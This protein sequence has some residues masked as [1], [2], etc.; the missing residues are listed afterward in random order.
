MISRWAINGQ[1]YAVQAKASELSQGKKGFAYYMDMGLGKTAVALN[2][3]VESIQRD[4][5][6]GAIV[7]CINSLKSN[8]RA[9]VVSWGV[10]VPVTLWPD[11][12]KTVPF[13]WVINFD[14]F[15]YAG[16]DEVFAACRKHR[17][18]CFIDESQKIK[19]PNG[20]VSKSILSLR[21]EFVFKRLLSGSPMTNTVM[22]LWPQFNF[23]GATNMNPYAFRNRF[24]IT[25]GYMGK[26]V[27]G[28][29]NEDLLNELKAGFVFRA[30]KDEW[31]DLPEKV[32][33]PP[34]EIKMS[35]AQLKSY[36]GMHEDL[37]VLISEL[38]LTGDETDEVSVNLVVT[39]LI[40]LQQ[41]AAG[42]IITEEGHV[43]ELVPANK[44][45]RVL[46]TV[47]VG[48]DTVGKILVFCK[49]RYAATML[50]AA[51]E[52]LGGC[53][54]IVGGMTDDELSEEKSKF[55]CDGGNRWLVAQSSVGST[56]HTLLGGIGDNRCSTTVFFENDFNWGN[57]AQSEDRNHRIGQDKAVVYID[58]VASDIDR[59]IIHALQKKTALIRQVVD[60]VKRPLD[61]V[62]QP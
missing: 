11:K 17:V 12:P 52:P 49:H 7:I 34:R 33:P 29:K 42:F 16:Y 3:T 5:I 41:I 28:V 8:W 57:R 25:G 54:K 27:V 62:S 50:I 18:A 51:L 14:A 22:D 59:K 38:G 32:Y 40:K 9:E 1:P 37:L 53:S 20:A 60:G 39:Q 10:N 26:Q 44:N 4:V 55:N 45:Q 46:E 35:S 30:I 43:V 48:E 56:G 21:N 13:I 15:L 2:E 23:I 61:K 19:N 58:F 24:A 6:D 31:L 36:Q 47:A